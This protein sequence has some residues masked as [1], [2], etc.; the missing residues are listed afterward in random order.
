MQA[1]GC[2]A[3]I[4]LDWLP[5]SSTLISL[6]GDGQAARLAAASAGDDYELLF[7]A[8]PERTGEIEAL[9]EEL[10][11]PLSAIGQCE[12]GAGLT[13]LDGD[14]PVPLPAKLGFEHG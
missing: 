1:S 9:A 8:S 6:D 4:R 2:A 11:L 13:L 10:G 5:L 7:A 14:A 3:A 12:S